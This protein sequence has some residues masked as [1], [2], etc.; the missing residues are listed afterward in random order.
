V[1]IT[2]ILVNDNED[3]YLPDG[4]NLTIISGKDACAQSVRQRT[5]MRLGENQYN[6]NEGVDY[7]GTIFAPQVNYDAARKSISDTIMTTP[8]VISVEQLTITIDGNTFEY[9]ADVM[10]IYGQIPISTTAPAS[11]QST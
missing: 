4:R 6:V 11:G 3:I 9:E 1:A 10:T 5:K 7:F 8:D 2:T